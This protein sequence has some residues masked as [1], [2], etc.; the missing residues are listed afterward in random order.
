MISELTS[1]KTQVSFNK[2]LTKNHDK[3]TELWLR[4]YKVGSDVKSITYN[5]ALEEALCFGWIDGIRKSV[6]ELSYTIRFTPRKKRSIWSVVNIRKVNELIE[7]GKMKQPGLDAFTKRDKEKTE[8]YS[9][10]RKASSLEESHEKRFKKNKKAWK[11]FQL[12][13]PWY[14]RTSTWWVISAKKEETRLKRLDELI[15]DSFEGRRIK[16]L[17]RPVKGK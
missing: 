14:Q 6:D 11:F 7:A 17:I 13:A 1:F 4:F 2:W 9:Y 3:A 15:K 5:E 16:T 12:Q 8:K 10:E